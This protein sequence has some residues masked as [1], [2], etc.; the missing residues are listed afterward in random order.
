M[1]L[2]SRGIRTLLERESKEAL[3]ELRKLARDMKVPEHFVNDCVKLALSVP[4]KP[5]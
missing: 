5:N 2:G 3:E 4:A 1:R